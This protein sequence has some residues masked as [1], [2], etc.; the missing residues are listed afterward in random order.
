MLEAH[1]RRDS[2]ML[3]VGLCI[4]IILWEQ[5]VGLCITLYSSIKTSLSIPIIDRLVFL[6]RLIE[7]LEH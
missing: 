5:E 4:P 6:I 7:R 2:I 3:E 1:K